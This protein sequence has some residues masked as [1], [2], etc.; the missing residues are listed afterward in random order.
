L[1]VV[2]EEVLFLDEVVCVLPAMSCE[3]GDYQLFEFRDLLSRAI[4]HPHVIVAAAAAA[5]VRHLCARTSA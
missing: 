1:I 4:L 3:P 2:F 5:V